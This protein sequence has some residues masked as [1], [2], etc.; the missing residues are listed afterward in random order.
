MWTR[1]SGSPAMLL[2]G[3]RQIAVMCM[4]T[5]LADGRRCSSLRGEP[6]DVPH[7]TSALTTPF[8]TLVL[9]MVTWDHG[10]CPLRVTTMDR[11]VVSEG[12]A[13]AFAVP[14][15]HMSSP[16]THSGSV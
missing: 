12:C 11:R 14:R 6:R 7:E 13:S 8:E 9:R 3:Y 2:T 10:I 5:S 15:S 4:A 1:G 16:A